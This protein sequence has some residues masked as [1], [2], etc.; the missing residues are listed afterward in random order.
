VSKYRQT[1]LRAALL[2]LLAVVACK[3]LRALCTASRA[4]APAQT[5]LV[6][7]LD[8]WRDEPASFESLT[9]DGQT[10]APGRPFA[11]TAGWLDR[12]RITVKNTSDRPI[13]K[14]TAEINVSGGDGAPDVPRPF[15]YNINCAD[16]GALPPIAPG[17]TAALRF[18]GRLPDDNE[19]DTHPLALRFD[20][21]YWDDTHAWIKGMEF[22]YRPER[23]V[24]TP[25]RRAA[26]RYQA[27]AGVRVRKA[28]LLVI[29]DRGVR[30]YTNH[31]C[32]A[33]CLSHYCKYSTRTSSAVRRCPWAIAYIR[34]SPRPSSARR[35]IAT[36][37]IATT[38]ATS[39]RT[40]ALARRPA[41]RPSSWTCSATGTA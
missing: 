28:A 15:S 16:A 18:Q 19:F 24:W 14:L 27:P 39:P 38:S 7:K 13:A 23:K 17:E 37:F 2:C 22:E 36:S 32:S 30:D 41:S 40:A 31:D 1:I 25:L 10:L 3:A 20:H 8:P 11:A 34:R 9:L 33:S 35:T 12:L 26:A 6:I 21:V 5:Q 4:A 29:C